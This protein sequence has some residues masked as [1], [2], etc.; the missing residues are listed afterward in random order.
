LNSMILKVFSN[1][2]D[3]VILRI[4]RQEEEIEEIKAEWL[5]AWSSWKTRLTDR[6]ML[7]RDTFNGFVSFYEP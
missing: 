4:M 2:Y 3:S 7:L 6:T 5:K 1:L